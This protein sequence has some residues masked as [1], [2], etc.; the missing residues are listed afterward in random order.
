MKPFFLPRWLQTTIILLENGLVRPIAPILYQKDPYVKFIHSARKFSYFVFTDFSYKT[1]MLLL[2]QIELV[3]ADVVVSIFYYVLLYCVVL[4]K[5]SVL[6]FFAGR[7]FRRGKKHK[8][9]ISYIV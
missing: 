2:V 9:Q 1:C 8:L 4:N 7:N 3:F 5:V 6:S